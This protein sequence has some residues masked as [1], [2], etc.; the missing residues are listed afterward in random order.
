MNYQFLKPLLFRLPAEAAHKLAIRALK[1]DWVGGVDRRPRQV[2]KQRIWGLDFFSPIGLAAGF[3]KNAEVPDAMLKAG[4]GFTECGTITPLPQEGNPKP[5]IFRLVRDRAV[6]NRL[7]FNNK[8]LEAA[9]TLLEERKRQGRSGIVGANIGANKTSDDRMADYVTCLE[10][11]AGL[12]QYFVVNISSPNTPGLRALQSRDALSELVGRVLETRNKTYEERGLGR[13]AP[14][15]VKVAPDLTEDDIDDIAAVA[16]DH[17]LDG[18][19][20]SNTTIARPDS[21]RSP[22]RREEGGLSGAPLLEP[23]TEVL[24]AFY[25]RVG[26]TVP[27][28]G[29]GGVA[30][31]ADAMK[32]IKAG[33]TLVQLYSALVYEGPFLA[34]KIADDL[35]LRL[36]AEG[37]NSI[38]DA[39]G[40]DHRAEG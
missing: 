10:R 37:F 1:L 19:I 7:G 5:R 21:L 17:A 8:G 6:I 18:L 38:T 31:A 20:I 28:I 12:A 16:L 3:D 33:A 32:K 15:L 25:K 39:I 11:L 26:G 2:L 22:K 40:A 30:N 35:A 36:K 29:V 13:P 4:F 27:L 9:A 34:A 23:S 14:L 24:S